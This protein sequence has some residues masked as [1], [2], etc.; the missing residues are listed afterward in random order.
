MFDASSKYI[1]SAVPT[2]QK[3]NSVSNQ[4]SHE[5]CNFIKLLMQ[6]ILKLFLFTDIST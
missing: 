6:N 3:S 4:I 5:I 1:R 2:V